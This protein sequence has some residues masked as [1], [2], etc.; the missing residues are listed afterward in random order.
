MGVLIL[1]LIN[2]IMNL[3]SVPAYPQEIIK[4]LIII[5]AVLLQILNKRGL[6]IMK[7]RDVKII[8]SILAADYARLGEEVERMEKAGVDG[9]HID[10]M[11]GHFVE[12]IAFGPG[13]VKAIRPLTKL[14]LDAHLM[15]SK[16]EA[17][18]GKMIEAGIDMIFIHV[19]SCED[20]LYCVREIRKKGKKAGIAVDCATPISDVEQIL[21]EVDA[22]L[23]ISVNLGI[24]GQ[25]Y[26]EQITEKIKQTRDLLQKKGLH[27]VEIAVDGG[28][29]LLNI[30]KVTDAG[31]TFAIIGTAL[32]KNDNPGETVKRIRKIVSERSKP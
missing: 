14:G 20:L 5:F 13:F 24:G 17:V 3:L 27:H 15:V 9:I 30:K 22:V 19:E 1:G 21:P 2:N 31:V 12:D 18:I 32:L 4:G 26:K 29:S 25:E 8:A 28:I 16:P 11:D 7:K 10:I 23:L 6:C